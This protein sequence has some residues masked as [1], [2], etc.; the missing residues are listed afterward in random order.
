MF[1]QKRGWSAYA[2]R[3]FGEPHWRRGDRIGMA[4]HDSPVNHLEGASLPEMGVSEE[5]GTGKDGTSGNPR[6]LQD[7]HHF[8]VV[9]LNSPLLNK[10]VQLILIMPAAQAISKPILFDPGGTADGLAELAPFLI[11]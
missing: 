3:G 1:P 6:F 2:D 10:L 8:I 9:M 7:I 11:G 5:L 4:S